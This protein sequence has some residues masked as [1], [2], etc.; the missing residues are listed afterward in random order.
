MRNIFQNKIVL[1]VMSALIML[2]GALF[3]FQPTKVSAQANVQVQ[4]NREGI[5]IFGKVALTEGDPVEGVDLSVGAKKSRWGQEQT[6]I[7]DRDTTDGNGN[8]KLWVN[9]QDIRQLRNRDLVF[10]VKPDSGAQYEHTLDLEAGDIASITIEMR[11]PV[12]PIFPFTI[13]VY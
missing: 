4:R 6:R 9:N 1:G 3:I 5:V 8:Y 12:V 10:T 13:F 2:S 7:F 11:T